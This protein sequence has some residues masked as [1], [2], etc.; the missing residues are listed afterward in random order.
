MTF[1]DIRTN[2]PDLA[3]SAYALE[4]GGPVTL[5]VLTPD[6]VAYTFTRP[7]LLEA[8]ELA[9]PAPERPSAEPTPAPAASI[10]D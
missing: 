5:E 6:G 3:V 9:F 7:T 4:P 2:H 1:D 10:F 8:I